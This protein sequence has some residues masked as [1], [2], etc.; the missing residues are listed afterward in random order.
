MA[1]AFR[2]SR[3]L[4]MA[5]FAMTPLQHD[6]NALNAANPASQVLV[7]GDLVPRDDNEEDES[8]LQ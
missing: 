7:E 4:V 2:N 8:P 6:L 1:A 3:L 5:S